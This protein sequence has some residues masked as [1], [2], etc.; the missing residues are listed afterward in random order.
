MAASTTTSAAMTK[1][2][3]Y[4]GQYSYI[5]QTAD[6]WVKGIY[7]AKIDLTNGEISYSK[8]DQVFNLI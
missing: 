8:T 6:A 3:G 2:T 4:I 7:V 5:C 1:R